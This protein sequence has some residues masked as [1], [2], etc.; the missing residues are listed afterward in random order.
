MPRFALVVMLKIKPNSADKFISLIME[1]RR[2]SLANEEGCRNFIVMK[3]LEEA[4]TFHFYEEYDNLDAFKEHQ[5]SE[6]FKKYF[7]VAKDL[8]VER[9]WHR[10]EVIE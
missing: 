6:H 5:N 8:M 3:N 2:S 4:D 1:N 7:D 10:C 9:V